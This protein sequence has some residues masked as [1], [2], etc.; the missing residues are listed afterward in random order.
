MPATLEKKADPKSCDTTSTGHGNDQ[1]ALTGSPLCHRRGHFS[2]PRS[3]SSV[4][5]GND[6]VKEKKKIHF[7][8]VTTSGP[9]ELEPAGGGSGKESRRRLRSTAGEKHEVRSQTGSLLPDL[10]V[11]TPARRCQRSAPL[12]WRRRRMLGSWGGREA[13]GKEGGRRGTTSPFARK[14]WTILS[15]YW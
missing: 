10:F 15:V 12:N 6:R 5:Q 4:L 11:A 2:P 13:G 1:G 14:N 3:R 7:A 9:K 8:K